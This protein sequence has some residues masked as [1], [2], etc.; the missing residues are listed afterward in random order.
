VDQILDQV[1]FVLEV[2]WDKATQEA[3][4]YIGLVV[5][6]VVVGAAAVVLL[7]WLFLLPGVKKRGY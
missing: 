3:S 2:A 5:V 6:G 1:K 7:L 4:G